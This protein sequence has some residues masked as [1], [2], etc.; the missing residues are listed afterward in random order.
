MGL[1][2]TLLIPW[3]V[4]CSGQQEVTLTDFLDEVTNVTAVCKTP[5]GD[6]GMVSTYDRTGGNADWGNLTETP[7]Q[8]DLYVLADLKGPGCVKRIWMTMRSGDWLFFFDGETEPRIRTSYLSQLDLFGKQ[9]PFLPPLCDMVSSGP[10]CY[11]PIPFENSLRIAIRF[12]ATDPS[13]RGYYHINYELYPAG[14]KVESY[15]RT[16]SPETLAHVDAVRDAW[17]HA[18]EAAKTAAA[19]CSRKRSLPVS[20]GESATWLN[21][22][23]PAMLKAWTFQIKPSGQTTAT[24]RA[25]LLRELVLRFYWDGQTEPSVEVPLGDFFCNGLYRQRFSSMPLAV[26]DNAFVCRFPMPFKTS[27]RAELRNDG[28]TPVTIE[29]SYDIR[30]LDP[31]VAKDMSYFHACWNQTTSPGRPHRV[32][33]A[34]GAGHYVGCYLVSIGTDGSWNMLESDEAIYLDGEDTASMHG[35]GLEDYFNGAW[36]YNGLFYRPLHGLLEKAAM[37]T[38]QYRFHLLDRI[39]FD[40]GFLMNWEFGADSRNAGQGYMSSVAYWYQPEPHPAGT[41]MPPVDQRFPP[42]DK[43]ELSSIMTG[44]FELERIGHY[45]EAAERCDFFSERFTATEHASMLR[46]RGAAYR[47]LTHGFDAV[48]GDYEQIAKAAPSFPAGQQAQQL[49]WYHETTSNAILA[50]QANMKAKLYVDGNPAG[51]GENPYA[52]FAFPVVLTPGAHEIEAEVTP[53]SPGP[54]VSLDLRT[55]TTNLISDGTW[56][57]SRARPSN[58]PNTMDTVASWTNVPALSVSLPTMAWWQFIPNGF[59]NMQSGPRLITS[60]W[61]GWDKQPFVTTYL[62]KRF[63]VPDK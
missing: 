34:D 54:W 1:I 12:H 51:A 35:T 48:R 42:P 3:L 49:L 52:L 47:E 5:A 9:E 7:R 29:T 62:R 45:E 50:T 55:H 21:E 36:Y 2:I 38:C 57:Y 44:L 40:K 24:A 16:L 17:R 41:R 60:T 46:L 27:A 8:G 20:P 33:R 61:D 31:S 28:P 18:D 32:L 10:Y 23:G 26:L 15:P 53:L 4:G 14:T 19:E 58:W 59:V 6:P 30:A 11:L 25:R 22:T 43:L 37:R 56:E 63:V 39:R 13:D